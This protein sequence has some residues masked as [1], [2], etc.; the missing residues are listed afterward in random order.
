MNNNLKLNIISEEKKGPTGPEGPPGINGRTGR[1]GNKGDT[2]PPG[3]N[4]IIVQSGVPSGTVAIGTFSV[5]IITGRLWVYTDT[6][7]LIKYD[8]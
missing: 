3:P 4:P 7:H 6:W 1:M 5:D 2:G 8:P